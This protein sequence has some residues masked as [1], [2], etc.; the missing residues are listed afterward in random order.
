MQ[1]VANTIKKVNSQSGYTLLETAVVLLIIGI[2]FA[3]GSMAYQLYRVEQQNQKTELARI[4]ITLAIDSYRD[5]FGRY[6]CPASYTAQR[7]EPAYG[8]ET[9]CADTSVAPGN[10]A[11][12]I[13]IENS[14]RVVTRE[15]MTTF[16]PR[17]RR[18]A[19]PFRV[20]N[21]TEGEFY[22]A[23]GGRFSYAVTENLTDEDTFD[24]AEGGIG[25]V[26]GQPPDGVSL[27]SPEG[28]G[29]YFI[30]SHGRDNIGAYDRDGEEI[31]P[32]NG[33]MY[34]V[35]N[36]N[37]EDD[38][39][40]IYRYAKNSDAPVVLGGVSVPTGPTPPVGGVNTH[41]DDFAVYRAGDSTPIWKISEIGGSGDNAHD[42]L[43]PNESVVLGSAAGTEKLRTQGDVRT[44]T[45]I[46]SAEI[47]TDTDCFP[48][49][50]IGG[51][52]MSCDTPGELV[53]GVRYG[54]VVCAPPGEIACADPT[55]FIQRFDDRGMPVCGT[56]ASNIFC[57]AATRTI[58][59][60]EVRN[61]LRSPV[62][63]IVTLTAGV[64]RSR[65][66]RCDRI[67]TTNNGA[68][69]N[70]GPFTG[71]CTCTPSSNTVNNGAGSCGLGYGGA[72]TTTTTTVCPSGTTT[73]T[74]SRAA[75]V[76]QPGTQTQTGT[77]PSPRT[78]TGATQTRPITCVGGAPVFGPWTT[79]VPANCVCNPRAPQT[80]AL[81]CPA[82][83][84]GTA[85]RTRTWD[86]STC[87]W[88]PW[89]NTDNC[90]CTETTQ[91]RTRACASP[92]TGTINESRTYSCDSSNWGAWTEVSNDCR[93]VSRT[94]TRSASCPPGQVG[95]VTESRTVDCNG[96]PETAWAQTSSTCAPPLVC[97]WTA[98]TTLSPT[99]SG[100]IAGSSG[101]T[102][103]DV[104]NCRVRIGPG[105]FQGY[106]NCRCE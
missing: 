105:T 47:C 56:F 86:T 9:N 101:C 57:P 41:Y 69:V 54:N 6:P 68:W 8:A 45:E 14:P 81:S 20:L 74:T 104:G 44:D 43:D 33:P 84:T 15:D 100:P 11:N 72:T 2:L 70:V 99:N 96:A 73:S 39:L 77:C 78:G 85:S 42:L 75:C 88:G 89:V 32:C 94:E 3:A 83:T 71:V 34:D 49:R 90:I 37:T 53:V 92:L 4:R 36:C 1:T 63:T 103:G 13:C 82:N 61:L 10:C 62:N 64:S 17:V 95:T 25:V 60:G 76:C 19:I 23:F 7:D 48:S 87:N 29:L 59:P 97:S 80:E 26:D 30:F 102:C 66:Y 38:P 46:Q 5:R 16:T 65:Q 24:V 55:Q 21:L 22:D 50:L 18:G 31:L 67:G 51:S 58:C 93:C 40:A 79:T 35:Q 52:G 12:G 27:V 28:S 91:T 106:Q 98:S